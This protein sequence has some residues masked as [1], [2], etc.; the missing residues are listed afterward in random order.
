M[1][2]YLF[3]WNP[4]NFPWSELDDLIAK[5][6]A[7]G[8]ADSW[9]STVT[10]HLEVGSRF[11]LMRVAG[12]PRGLIASGTITSRPQEVP[13]WD[14]AR[15][16]RGDTYHRVDIRYETL[17]RLPLVRRIEL[18]FPPYAD[19]K[20]DP[21]ASGILIDPDIAR[22]LDRLWAARRDQP[23]PTQYHLPSTVLARWR[24][25]AQ[26]AQANASWV[27]EH[28]VRDARRRD[29]LPEINELLGAFLGSRI[30][31]EEL[32]ETLD[33]KSRNE[34]DVFGIK[35]YSG[36][37]FL[38]RLFKRIEDRASLASQLKMALRVPA[39]EHD[40]R[41]QLDGFVA[42]LESIIER[43]AATTAELHPGR[44]L[45]FLTV[46]WHLQQPRRWPALY[47]SARSALHEDGLLARNLFGGDGYL[48][49]VALYRALDSELGLSD[50]GLEHVFAY[51][52]SNG[53]NTGN[54]A[55]P[56][57]A[58]VSP[59]TPHVWL[60]APGPGAVN[61]DRDVREGIA[62]IDAPTLGDLG[63]YDDM[64]EILAKLQTVDGPTP[65]HDARACYEFSQVME[66]G[67]V[68]FAKHGRKK[69]IGYGIVTSAY[70]YDASRSSYQHVRKVDWKK[71]GEWVAREKPLVTKMLTDIGSYS[72]L[73]AQIRAAL[74]L[75][76]GTR[77]SPIEVPQPPRP[78]YGMA[79]AR[80]DL[81]LSEAWLSQQL[82]LLRYRKNI[83]LQGPPGVGKTFVAKRLAYLLLGERDP[84]RVQPVQFHPSYSYEDFIQG[85]RPVEGGGFKRVNGVF[86]DFCDEAL[87]N[88]SDKYVF[89]IDE[90]NRGNLG[91]IFGELL[92]LLEADK[93]SKDWAVR[94]TYSEGADDSFHIPPNLYVIGTMNTA[95]RSLALVDYALRRRFAFID[96]PPAI[97]TAEFDA[98]LAKLGVSPALRQRLRARV[99]RL[100]EVI[101]RDPDLGDGFCIGHSYF[102]QPPQEQ[103]ADEEWYERIVRTELG[104]LL[105]EYWFDN[106]ASAQTE[107]DR[108]LGSD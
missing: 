89:I 15:A 59:P 67:D 78:R 69:I 21:Q 71:T 74:D 91:K 37:G 92:M 108:L 64:D 44:S 46:L 40:A 79:D 35:G 62:A 51:A 53:T 68:I 86:H 32:K 5:V 98:V 22:D 14:P 20:W 48:E 36:A 18:D 45:F 93:R 55:G 100:N 103:E 13:H 107:L 23:E 42:Y 29:V 28:R 60:Y 8:H 84:D 94:L 1:D 52:A 75:D 24:A 3:A 10:K 26:D 4:E 2:H 77:G 80:A 61:W 73:V 19:Q 16:S 66:V 12:E 83:V 33:K 38:N 87:Q 101:R 106:K 49:F 54:T 56:V 17:S 90:I 58:G 76:G 50:W 88:P 95:D 34:W 85:Y 81:F 30:E 41:R 105:R 47:D 57:G 27:E 63:E 72:G 31:L 96:V 65:I 104:P 70:R 11:Y 7:Q 9:W 43:G 82:E 39:T 25:H 99:S 97:E 6:R 102:C